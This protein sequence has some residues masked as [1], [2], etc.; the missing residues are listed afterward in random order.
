[1]TTDLRIPHA[2]W[3][4]PRQARWPGA[5]NSGPSWASPAVTNSRVAVVAGA[6]V[7]DDAGGVIAVATVDV[8]VGS[9]RSS[10]SRGDGNSRTGHAHAARLSRRGNGSR[11]RSGSDKHQSNLLHWEPLCSGVAH[12]RDGMRKTVVR[13]A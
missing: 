11:E 13:S 12:R 2:S 6:A 9:D 1:M 3:S 10:G 4:N 8:S 7:I 5:R